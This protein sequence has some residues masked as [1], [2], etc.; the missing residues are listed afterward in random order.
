MK[1]RKL[2][3]LLT[4]HFFVFTTMCILDPDGDSNSLVESC[5]TLRSLTG[6]ALYHPIFCSKKK[7]GREPLFC[8]VMI[9]IL[10]HKQP[11]AS[12]VGRLSVFFCCKPLD[13]MSATSALVEIK[14]VAVDLILATDA[15]SS[16]DLKQQVLIGFCSGLICIWNLVLR[17]CN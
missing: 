17:N 10:T 2:W 4:E 7:R 8:H 13:E 5:Q 1:S 6:R 11:A 9:R 3:F 15:F 14:T 16:D 12:L